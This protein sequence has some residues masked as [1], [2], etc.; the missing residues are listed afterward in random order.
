MS[1]SSVLVLGA[2]LAGLSAVETLRDGGFDGR[3]TVVD[4]HPELPPDRPPLSK[5]VLAGS[6]EPAAASQ[7]LAHRLDDFDLD[8]RLGLAATAFDAAERRVTL[9]D[10]STETADGIVLATGSAPRHLATDLAGVH[11]LR[12]LEDCLAIRDELDGSPKVVVIGAGFIGAEVAATCRGR[13]L[14]VTMIEALERPMQRV[15]PGE[16]GDFVT[17]LHRGEGVDVRLGVGI[18]SLEGGDR[19]ERV[20]LSDDT[21][22]DADVVIAGIG[23][24]PSIGWLE[25]SGLTLENGVRCDETCLAAPG[26]VAAGDLANWYNPLYDEVMRVE[27]W[28]N[29][30]EQGAYAARRLMAGDAA[31]D[32]YAPVPWFWTDQYD[33]KLQLAGRVAPGDAVEVIEGSLD[34]RRFVAAFRRDDR[35]V[36]VLGVNRP[37]HVVQIRMKMNQPLPWADALA[38]FD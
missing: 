4:A 32:P 37:R 8:L 17:E 38:H 7:P 31:V 28:E 12:T 27:Q 14:D 10:G 30:I 36:G 16:I 5:Q 3:I 15:M 29:A 9:A 21:T 18:D 34:E 2:S 26:V 13:G 25:G 1:L 24:N 22:I 33:R 11:V 35:C 6:M 23:V 19:V 20:R